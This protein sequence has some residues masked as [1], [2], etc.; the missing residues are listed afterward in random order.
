MLR[1]LLTHHPSHTMSAPDPFFKPIGE[2]VSSSDS[3]LP[4][5]P[6]VPEGA[7]PRMVEEIESLCMACEQN[8]TTRML[9]TYIP[10]FKEVIVVSFQ[11]D[12]CGARNNEI[13]SAGQIQGE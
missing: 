11:C 10:Y 9:L 8:G 2:H 6:G 7:A 13:Q 4:A 3:D 12:H 5:E 1:F